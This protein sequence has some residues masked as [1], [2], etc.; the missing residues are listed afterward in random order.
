[1]KET[2]LREKVDHM[3]IAI[4]KIIFDQ[5]TG[6]FPLYQECCFSTFWKHFP[7][8][9]EFYKFLDLNYPFLYN[10]NSPLLNNNPN[11]RNEFKTL[12]NQSP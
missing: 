11:N 12:V 4:S 3:E 1:M 7:S 2:K 5:K 6:I 10:Y 9:K 8:K